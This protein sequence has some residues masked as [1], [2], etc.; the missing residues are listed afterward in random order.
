MGFPRQEYWSELPFPSPG[1]LPD[2][3]I[4]PALTGRFFTTESPG[5]LETIKCIST[6]KLKTVNKHVYGFNL[7]SIFYRFR[8]SL[9]EN[10]LTDTDSTTHNKIYPSLH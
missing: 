1:D 9:Q 4:E 2:P 7:I 10:L 5:K 6:D 8:S 3:E